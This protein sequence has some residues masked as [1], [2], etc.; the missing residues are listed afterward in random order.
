[1]RA[2]PPPAAPRA[3][4]VA[5]FSDAAALEAAAPWG[6]CAITPLH[7]AFAADLVALDLDDIRLESGR[8]SPAAVVG[9]RPPGSV[10]IVLPLDAPGRVRLM[11]RPA[12][13]HMLFACG[14][15][16]AF[17]VVAT[18]EARWALVAL[19]AAACGRLLGIPAGSCV[20]RAGAIALYRADP[21][22][23]RGLA[24]LLGQAARV[25]RRSPEI[26]DVAE[27]RRSL[28]ASV[29]EALHPLLARAPD[30]HAKC[31]IRPAPPGARRIVHAAVDLLG[32]DPARAAGPAPL[33]A[34]I[35]VAEPR[36]RR[37]FL[38]IL[39]M[40]PDRYLLR[41]RLLMARA[42]LRVPEAPSVPEVAA[43]HGFGHP[44]QVHR[45]YRA[46]FAEAPAR[47]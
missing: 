47:G 4:Q 45:A 26:F 1:M 13:A 8:C 3:V 28:R 6:R 10:A 27:T 14:P 12:A 20:A 15:G 16:A 2:M 17:E 19:P 34:A 31:P 46:L 29:I 9:V 7:P 39:G 22:A 23:W 37:A 42:A 24:V 44:R 38:D 11:G 21:V 32:A 41:R 35:G 40:T 33:A 18:Q 5:R 30:G 25:A 43:A 36:L